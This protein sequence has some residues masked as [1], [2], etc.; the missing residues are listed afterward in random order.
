[1]VNP[2]LMTY[3][4]CAHYAGVSFNGEI[5]RFQCHSPNITGRYVVVH[6]PS[7]VNEILTLCEVEIFSGDSSKNYNGNQFALGVHQ[8]N[9]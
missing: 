9:P 2:R 6:L 5:I 4:L 1:M 7:V 3:A 8:M